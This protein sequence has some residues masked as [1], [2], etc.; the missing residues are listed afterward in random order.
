MTVEVTSV[1]VSGRSLKAYEI[2]HFVGPKKEKKVTAIVCVFYEKRR[3]KTKHSAV[4]V[5]LANRTDYDRR[6]STCD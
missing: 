4:S 2:C 3:L 1:A 6:R 5:F